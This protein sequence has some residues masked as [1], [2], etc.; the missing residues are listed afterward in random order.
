[1]AMGAAA[2]VLAACGP[3]PGG[4]AASARPRSFTVPLYD[5]NGQEVA[6]AVLTQVGRDSVRLV[7]QS[8]RVPAGQHGIHLHASGRCEAP[9]F[10]TAGPHLNPANR[11]HGLRN[12][13]GPHLGDMPNLAVGANG[14]G[15]A[16]WTLAGTLTP[17]EG[18]IFD[19]D[20][21]ALV[22]HAG[23]DD[24]ATDPAGNSGARIACGVI[25]AP[26]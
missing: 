11:Q 26:T 24:Q 17:G 15:R 1:M 5:A 23:A 25:A 9:G 20:G 22:I 19:P 7:T 4:T 13:Q 8:T 21:T 3:V 2:A 16:E 12:P 14:Q 18:A 10:Q 6:T